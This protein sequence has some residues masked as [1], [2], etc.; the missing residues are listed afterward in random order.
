MVARE[1]RA[2]AQ[3]NVLVALATNDPGEEALADEIIAL[4]G[5]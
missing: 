2:A 3:Q 1:V 5:D 4:A